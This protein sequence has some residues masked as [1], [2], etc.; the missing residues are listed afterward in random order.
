MRYDF[1]ATEKKWQEKWDGD[2]FCYEY[3]FWLQQYLD[4]SGMYLS[5]LLYD[6]ISALKG[7]GLSGIV[8]DGSQRSY[9][10]TGL[11]FYVYGET[12]YDK[13]RSFE[14]LVEDYFSHAFGPKWQEVVS[15][16]NELRD[17]F[18]FSYISG[19]G[20]VDEAKGAYYNPAKQADM[21]RVFELSTKFSLLIKAEKDQP[22]RASAVSWRLL[23]YHVEWVQ[24]LADVVRY[25][26][27][28]DTNLAE[29][30]AR[31]LFH[32]FSEYEV[33]IERNFDLRLCLESIGR[34][35][36]KG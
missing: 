25:L 13:S 29:K 11:P 14:E 6:D 22:R 10:P 35:G 28:D 24:G 23:E 34:L 21:D 30:Y 18:D 1:A 15:Y 7:R 3:H 19:Y 33:Y 36:F 16:L 20:T 9:F 27:V 2:C 5:K 12:L 4:Q 31:R 32:K 8:E 26:C 17:L